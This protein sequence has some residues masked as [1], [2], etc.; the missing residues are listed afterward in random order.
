[1]M[2]TAAIA[3]SIC[4]M[5]INTL[6]FIGKP[7][8]GKGT[9][10]TLLSEKTGWPA[11]S[12]GD[13]FRA[14]AKE[15]TP[16][17]RKYKNE[18]EQGFLAPDWFAAYLFQ[19]S[20]FALAPEDGIIFDGFGRKVPEAKIVIDVLTWLERPFRAVHIKVSDEE[21]HTRLSK[22][23]A[24]SGRADDSAID[25][26]LDEYRLHTDP[27]I[28]V[29]RN[30]GVLIEVNGEGSVEDIQADIRSKLGIA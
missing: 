5:E 3:V 23:A 14:F 9:Q 25:K 1:M 27:A 8:S 15:E 16:A 18:M 7:G 12:S 29:F 26:R 6:L 20:I 17:G 21:I 22:R 28:E 30:A 24:V 2:R 10:T 13:M 19:K 11:R 4:F